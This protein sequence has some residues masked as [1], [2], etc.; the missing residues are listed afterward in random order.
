[1]E[2][3]SDAQTLSAE[4]FDN[5]GNIWIMDDFWNKTF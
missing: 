4:I 2:K 3:G 5:C 1:M